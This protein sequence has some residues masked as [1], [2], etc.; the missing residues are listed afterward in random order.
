MV[1]FQKDHFSKPC[2]ETAIVSDVQGA[3]MS[4]KNT[5]ETFSMNQN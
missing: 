5:S 4:P 2:E 3:E 1:F